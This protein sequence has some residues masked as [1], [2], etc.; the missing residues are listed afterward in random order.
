MLAMVMTMLFTAG[1]VADAGLSTSNCD[2][3]GDGYS[4]LAIGAPGEA[5]GSIDGAGAVNVIYG[6]ASGLDSAGNQLWHQDRPGI[7]FDAETGDAFGAALACG[8]F[9]DDTYDDLAVGVP[10]ESIGSAN[11]RPGAGAVNVIYGSASGLSSADDQV[12][13]Q[14]SAGVPGAA[15]AGDRFGASLAVGDFDGDGI[16]DLAI[17][18]PGEDVGNLGNAGAVNV[19]LGSNAGLTATGSQIWHQDSPNIGGGAEGDDRFGE[20]LATGNF[21][22]DPYDDLAIGAPGEGVVVGGTN[23]ADAGAVHV[24]YGTA[25]GLSAVGDQLWHQATPG[26]RG[27]AEAWD[28]FGAALAAGDFNDDGEDDLAIGAPRDSVGTEAQ[29]GAVNVLLGSGS[30]LTAAGDQIWHQDKPGIKGRAEAGDVFGYSLVSADFDGD[31]NDDLGVGVPGEDVGSIDG[32]GAVNVLFG[33]NSGLTVR[34]QIYDQDK[35]GIKYDAEPG[36]A[37]GTTLAAGKYDG[38]GSDDIAIGV[39]N[40]SI[41]VSNQKVSAGAVAVIYGG[42]TSLTKRDDVWH[43]ARPGIAG[44]AE[45]FD[46]AGGQITSAGE[47]RIGYVNGTSVKV[48]RDHLS[49]TPTLRIDMFGTGGGSKTVAAAADGVIRVIVDTNSEPTTNNNYVWIEHP[50]G[51]WS[52]YSHMAQGT[53]TA[54]GWSVGDNVDAGDALGTESNV[55]QASGNHLHFQVSRPDDPA[56]P[57]TGG[58]FIIGEDLI[59]I[60]CGIPGNMYISGE[61]YT[62]GS[63]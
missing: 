27:A 10:H 7:K 4:D 29:A 24:F 59:P 35:Q 20:S 42:A 56:N 3:N 13:H 48:S 33:G 9:D 30:G 19:L 46:R 39:P 63:C 43:Q 17:G 11:P 22:G 1:E 54:L 45:S 5:I 37:F 28:I 21:D 61:T 41:G 62:A 52:K 50:N 26:V 57:I 31:G 47:Y 2:F 12:W 38:D 49:H 23:L 8:D 53:V 40:E 55:G 51:E 44:K 6:T 36:D 14:A 60:I 18:A 16:E 25:S 34:D 58:G 32:A 15:E